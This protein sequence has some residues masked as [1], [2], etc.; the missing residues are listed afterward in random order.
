M[1]SLC[2]LCVISVSSLLVHKLKSYPETLSTTWYLNLNN[3]YIK[4]RHACP[5]KQTLSDGQT[6]STLCNTRQVQFYVASYNGTQFICALVTSHISA[7]SLQQPTIS[8]KSRLHIDETFL[9]SQ[10][11]TCFLVQLP[12]GYFALGGNFVKQ[13]S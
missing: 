3:M 5:W 10:K 1:S 12:S 7:T 2:H 9:D 11:A 4:M 6:P 8:Q 13:T